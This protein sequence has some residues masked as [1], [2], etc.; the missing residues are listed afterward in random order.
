MGVQRQYNESFRQQALEK[1]YTRGNR[2]VQSVAEELE[3]SKATLRNW[4]KV[5]EKQ[6]PTRAGER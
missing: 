6:S 1:V 4:M 5:K 2:S 3:M